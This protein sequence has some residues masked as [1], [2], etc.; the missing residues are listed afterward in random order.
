M[1]KRRD[2]TAP[3]LRDARRAQRSYRVMVH[4]LWA[5]KAKVL[6]KSLIDGKEIT[7][8]PIE[9]DIYDSRRDRFANRVICDWYLGTSIAKSQN[10]QLK[11]S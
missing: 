5:E 3:M 10:I 11:L 2:S 9:R 7:I 8:I 6:L 1:T 4:W